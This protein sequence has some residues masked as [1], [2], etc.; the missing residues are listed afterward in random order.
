MRLGVDA[1]ELANQPA[2]KGQYLLRLLLIWKHDPSLE[3]FLYVK[4]GS[5]LP[6]ELSGPS[7]QIIEQA[8]KGPL[9]HRAVG[10]RLKS[11]GVTCFFAAL[12]YFSAL[13]NPVPTVTVVHDLAVFKVKGIAHNRQALVAERLLLKS[14][15]K[16]SARLIAVSE[17]T[18][19]DVLEQ[20]GVAPE[21]VVVIY[22]APLLESGTVLSRAQR[23]PYLLF[24]GTLEPR[25]N[26]STLLK[27][28]AGLSEE[29]R[30]QYP[31]RL[32]GKKGW[33]SE[34]Y[35]QLATDLHLSSQTHFLGYASIPEVTTHYQEATV[36]IYPSLYEGFGLPVAEALAC[37]T[38]TVS[39]NTSS[40]PE[41]GGE[42]VLYCD[43]HKPA[44]VTQAIEKLLTNPAEWE[45]RHQA[46]VTQ[47][48]RFSW[49]KAAAETLLVLKERPA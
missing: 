20:T 14:C 45:A 22:E 38:P 3:L 11:D 29:L 23:K 15:T 26:I 8:G 32:V 5:V 10:K 48:R 42:A 34:D 28:Y 12:S 2:G 19:R 7:I 24:V 1:R 17:C 49:E 41:V 44:E 9:W 21:K 37:G 33:G 16:K 6:G 40:L 31:L 35:E 4:P 46:S 13:C 30:N 36:F 25:K 47:G 27:A 43:P 39:S 18:K